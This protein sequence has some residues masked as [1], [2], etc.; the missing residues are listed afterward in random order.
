MAHFVCGAKIS[1]HVQTAFGLMVVERN[2]EIVHKDRTQPPGQPLA[3]RALAGASRP[4]YRNA[5]PLAHGYTVLP[6]D[7]LRAITVAQPTR[8]RPIWQSLCGYA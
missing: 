7:A 3:H 8:P 4:A 5:Q 6:G 2:D 1:K